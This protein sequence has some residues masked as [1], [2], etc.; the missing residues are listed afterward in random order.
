MI[1][2]YKYYAASLVAIYSA[3]IIYYQPPFGLMD[4][5]KNIEHIQNLNQ[6][7]FGYYMAYFYERT[8]EKGLLQPFYLLQM[9]F[10]YFSNSPIFVY[11]QNLLIVFVSLLVC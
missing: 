3:L 11:L 1:N 5:F 7:F 9:Y 4:D 2:K 8:F 6:D 10:Q